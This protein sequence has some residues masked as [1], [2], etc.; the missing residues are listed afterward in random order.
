MV[1]ACALLVV[2][3]TARG[4][5]AN[6]PDDVGGAAATPAGTYGGI[7][8][9]QYAGV[10]EGETSTGA[11][12]VPY[13]ITAPADPADG[14]GKVVVEPSHFAVGLEMLNVNLGRELLL[15]RGFS[16]A[17]IGWGLVGNRILD[18]SVPGTFIDG[19]T[20][21]Y[22]D[23]T[24]DE[25]VSE[26]ARALSTD[27]DAQT[28]LGAVHRR[29][30]VGLSDAANTVVRIVSSGLADGVFDLA[31]PYVA[32]RADN[33]W[34][35]D[36]QSTIGAGGYAGKFIAVNS[37]AEDLKGLL[38]LG[39]APSQYRSY[40]VAGTPHV[41]DEPT[42]P[43]RTNGST[44]A[45]ALP[46]LR[47]HFLQGD[48][49]V[50]D[51]ALPPTSTQLLS[52]NGK[53]LDRDAN[54]NAISVNIADAIVPRLPFIDLGEARYISGFIGRYDSVKTIG[55]LGFTDH[56]SYLAAFGDALEQ[57]ATAGFIL[58]SDA[59]DMLT[60][61]SLCPPL[62]YTETYRD[63]FENFAA[64]QPCTVS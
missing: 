8:Y 39:T 58:P 43:G 22:F 24:D 14:N 49:W 48:A 63:H 45:T 35:N 7:D 9:V 31:L 36:P 29:Y 18:P 51:G 44:P 3:A 50:N 2:F 54:G 19:G 21:R 56:A 32:E 6:Q 11:F 16:H 15:S 40:A 26:F 53:R 59:N 33:A 41:S 57:Y 27:L 10:F 5:S 52:S 34:I 42:E 38:D 17:G 47:A 60:R 4:G 28:M 13:Q 61:A 12:R 55:Q 30:L 20:E 37:E 1:L 25:I 46:Q 64:K 62:T 23:R